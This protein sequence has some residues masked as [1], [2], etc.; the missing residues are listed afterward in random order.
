M[1]SRDEIPVASK[2][3][4]VNVLGVGIS[5]INMFDALANIEC[6]IIAR[7]R[8]Y[9]C[10]TGVHGVMESK[11]DLELRRIHNAAA[12]VTPDGMP[13]VWLL[14]ASG[15]QDADRVYGPDMM[16]AVFGRSRQRGYRHFLY[17]A[18]E[19]TLARLKANLQGRFP[20]L[21]IVGTHSPPFR[22]LTA[23]EDAAVVRMINAA[24][25]DIVWVGLSTPKQ[26]RWMAEHRDRLEAPVLIGVGAAFDFHAGALRQCPRS[27]QRMG[28]EWLFRLAME[29]R[30]LW[31][32]YLRN[33]PE[34]I[35]CVF[36][37]K[38]GLRHYPLA[39]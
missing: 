2:A 6:W 5:A 15:Y 36:G 16:L 22:P 34:F 9:I 1:A 23:D 33:N 7:E 39:S 24:H 30:R 31:Q 29:P 20:G 27:L 14:W 26:E 19:V 18:S 4:R 35:V 32:R 21:C 17:G 25:P 12:M 10:V 8:H 28:F 11:R 3:D 13:L 37:Q 38:L